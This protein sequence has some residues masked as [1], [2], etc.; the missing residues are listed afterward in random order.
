[1]LFLNRKHGTAILDC[2]RQD[3]CG[4]LYYYYANRLCCEEILVGEPVKLVGEESA[5]TFFVAHTSS[6][7]KK[8]VPRGLDKMIN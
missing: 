3:A 4:R 6:I 2:G 8:L 7:Q 5:I 1:V